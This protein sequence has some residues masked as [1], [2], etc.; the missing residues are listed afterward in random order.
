M[1]RL[2]WLTL[3]FDFYL[4]LHRHSEISQF[5]SCS[6]AC[7]HIINCF[8]TTESW[9]TS[10]GSSPTSTFRTTHLQSL[11]FPPL[12][13][14]AP[15]DE[16]NLRIWVINQGTLVVHLITAHTQQ[17]S[18]ES[19]WSPRDWGAI[20]LQ[21]LLIPEIYPSEMSTARK[22]LTCQLGFYFYFIF[23]FLSPFRRKKCSTHTRRT[24][25]TRGCWFCS[26]MDKKNS[27]YVVSH[28]FTFCPDDLQEKSCIHTFSRDN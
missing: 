4:L 24:A 2:R 27:F 23:Y 5:S 25:A 9:T 20:N 13:L 3:K 6:L 28:R 26:K 11:L 8:T 21:H 15:P 10:P 19:D 14:T 7:V 16:V 18:A 12:A 22:L 1:W 17:L